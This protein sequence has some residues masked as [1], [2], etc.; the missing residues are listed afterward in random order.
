MSFCTYESIH[1]FPTIFTSILQL[2]AVRDGKELIE[3]HEYYV[4]GVLHLSESV[5]TSPEQNDFLLFTPRCS[6]L[7]FSEELSLHRD[8]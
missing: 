3:M 2:P 7:V 1:V 4:S 6:I 8:L 5:I